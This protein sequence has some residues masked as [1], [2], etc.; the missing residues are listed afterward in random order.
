MTMKTFYRKLPIFLENYVFHHLI[1][2][3]HP[4]E[5]SSGEHCLKSQKEGEFYTCCPS[6]TTEVK[7]LDTSLLYYSR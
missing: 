1:C 6:R 2:F 7:S 3:I 5:A 4:H